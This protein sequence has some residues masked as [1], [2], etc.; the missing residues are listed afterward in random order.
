MTTV[1]QQRAG[2]SAEDLL[3]Y[4][5]VVRPVLAFEWHIRASPKNSQRWWKISNAALSR[6][7]LSATHHT[8]KPEVDLMSHCWLTDVLNNARYCLD[9]QTV[10][11]PTFCSTCY[12]GKARYSADRPSAFSQNIA[13]NSSA[14]KPI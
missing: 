6:L 10:T 9:G 13:S 5:A 8:K 2:V 14:N 11:S 1:I 3:Y 7:L 4:Q 12:T